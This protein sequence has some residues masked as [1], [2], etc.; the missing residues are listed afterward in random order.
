MIGKINAIALIFENVDSMVI[1]A[2]KIVAWRVGDVTTN[3]FGGRYGDGI[4]KSNSCN[5]F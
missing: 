1:P 5:F 2:N 4:H 3:L